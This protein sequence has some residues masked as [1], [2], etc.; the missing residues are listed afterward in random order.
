MSVRSGDRVLITPS[1]IP[2]EEMKPEQIASM[3]I[4]GDYGAMKASCCPP[5]NGACISTS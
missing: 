4:E 1:A 5:A 3:P 2:Y